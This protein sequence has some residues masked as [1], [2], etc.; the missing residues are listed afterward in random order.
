M[1]KLEKI[2][3][4]FKVFGEVV[5]FCDEKFIFE[6]EKYLA[7]LNDNTCYGSFVNRSRLNKFDVKS[8]LFNGVNIHL[9][10]KETF[11]K[12]VTKN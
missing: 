3:E 9:A 11:I 7:S 5:I 6:V 12:L 10:S 1:E 2:S 8:V 4:V